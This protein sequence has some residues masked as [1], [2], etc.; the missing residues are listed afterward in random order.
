MEG[1]QTSAI[2]DAAA[3]DA[4]NDLLT[5]GQVAGVLNIG[6]GVLLVAA[7]LVFLSGFGVWV[8]HLGLPHRDEGL[9]AMEQGVGLLFIL[10][11][12]LAVVRFAQFHTQAVLQILAI[13]LILFGGGMVIAALRASGGG[14]D[15]HK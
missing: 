8:T 11:C 14:D 3:N 4:M 9:I 13:A 15:E 6:A 2:R 7:L 10:V 1:A 12:I 5:I